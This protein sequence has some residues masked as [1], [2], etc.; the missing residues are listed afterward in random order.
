MI[1]NQTNVNYIKALN[2][3]TFGTPEWLVLQFKYFPVRQV[4]DKI[5]D[6]YE[7]AELGYFPIHPVT[8]MYER[9]CELIPRTMHIYSDRPEIVRKCKQLLVHQT[10][11]PLPKVID[12]IW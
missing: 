3:V 2:K 11:K 1:R 6:Y 10:L 8:Q 12:E 5:Y 4:Y 9:M 7:Q